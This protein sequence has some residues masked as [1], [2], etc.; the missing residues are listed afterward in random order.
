MVSIKKKSKYATA[1][2][3]HILNFT[4]GTKRAIQCSRYFLDNGK[5]NL[6]KNCHNPHNGA[7]NSLSPNIPE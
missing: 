1:L 7:R 3:H 6:I 2:K 5:L 4:K